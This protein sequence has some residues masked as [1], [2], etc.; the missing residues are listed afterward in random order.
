ML[1]GMRKLK[2]VVVSAAFVAILE[3]DVQLT[4]S[5]ENYHLDHNTIVVI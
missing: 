2:V 5:L 1:I 3:G 4:F